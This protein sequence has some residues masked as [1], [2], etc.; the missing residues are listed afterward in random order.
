MDNCGDCTIVGIHTLAG[1]VSE[2]LLGQFVWNEL[3]MEI[4]GEVGL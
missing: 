3:I 2:D 1:S 4:E